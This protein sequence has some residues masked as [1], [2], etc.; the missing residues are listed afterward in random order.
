V[1]NLMPNTIR[2]ARTPQAATSVVVLAGV[3]ALATVAIVGDE[4]FALAAALVVSTVVFSILRPRVAVPV[5]IGY[6]AI[7]SGARRFLDYHYGDLGALDPLLVVAPAAAG[8]MAYLA[9]RSHEARP[10]TALG[11][12][13]LILFVIAIFGAFNPL[14]GSLAVG[15]VGFAF[16]GV[17]LL[18]FWVGRH[19]V[20]DTTLGWVL[21]MVGVAAVATGVYGIVQSAGWLFPW[22]ESWAAT[23]E[24]ASLRING[25]IKPFSTFASPGEFARYMSMGLL[26]WLV[27]SRWTTSPVSQRL[28]VGASFSVLAVALVVPSVRIAMLLTALGLGAVLAAR[29]RLPIVRAVWL[30][31]FGVVVLVAVA[32]AMIDR[33]IAGLADPI[34]GESTTFDKRTALFTGSLSAMVTNPLGEGTGITTLAATQF[35]TRPRNAETDVGDVAYSWGIPGVLTYV[36]VIVLG[37]RTSYMLAVRRQDWLSFGVLAV[38][39]AAGIQWIN[40]GLYAIA[41]VVWLCLGWADRRA[42]T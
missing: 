36:T 21:R 12:A 18:W 39:F 22:D 34:A 37:L 38:L 6:L 1:V 17:P 40:G 14:Q 8:S 2:S 33:Q 4:F 32:N 5:I 31:M 15:I 27:G 13:V 10:R 26:I 41:P 35:G 29:R 3:V 25:E 19:F 9:A 7:S 16:F 11:T 20:D 28:I 23:V 42:S 24:F 30:A